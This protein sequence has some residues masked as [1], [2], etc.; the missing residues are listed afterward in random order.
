MPPDR[1]AAQV[2]FLL[3]IDRLKH[4]LRQTWLVDSSRQENSAEHSW[5]L[6]VLAVVLAEYAAEKVDLLRVVKIALIHDVVEVDAGDAYVYDAAAMAQKE[7]REQAA[8]A[9]IFGLLPPDQAAELRAL[10]DEFEARQTPEARFARAL[11][12]FDPVLHNCVTQGKAW[13]DHGVKAPQVFAFNQ[14]MEDGAPKLW[15]YA[16]GLIEEA[17]RQGWLQE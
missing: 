13:R 9:R 7:A 4:V 3:E 15:E 16:R 12:R 10:W 2:R 8:A 11:D 6:A 14:H 17:V 5:M 1:L